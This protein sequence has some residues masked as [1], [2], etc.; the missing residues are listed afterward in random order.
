M[1][2]FPPDLW[3]RCS[4]RASKT[5]LGTQARLYISRTGLE[6]ASFPGSL[7]KVTQEKVLLYLKCCRL[8]SSLE[9]SIFSRM[10]LQIVA[11]WDY[12]FQR[13]PLLAANRGDFGSTDFQ[14][15][16]CQENVASWEYCFP[17]CLLFENPGIFGVL[18]S[19][20]FST[21]GILENSTPKMLKFVNR[22]MWICHLPITC[23]AS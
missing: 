16:P 21:R 5:V 18:L 13:S 10:S 14:D 6:I 9:D 23:V 8:C 17:R 12:C 20:I 3:K 4:L 11:S 2:L 15:H 19:K 22:A 1:Y 7:R